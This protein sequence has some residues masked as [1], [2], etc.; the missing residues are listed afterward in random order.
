MS[1]AMGALYSTFA[2]AS[3]PHPKIGDC[4]RCDALN[5]TRLAERMRANTDEL[6]AYLAR[7]P[8]DGGVVEVCGDEDAVGVCERGGLGGLAPEV[9]AV[10]GDHFDA[11]GDVVGEPV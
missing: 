5:A 8:R 3:K 11:L 7:E 9:A 6:F 4:G 10:A 1:E 2:S